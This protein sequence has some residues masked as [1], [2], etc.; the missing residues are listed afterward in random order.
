MPSTRQLEEFFAYLRFPS[1]S[2]DPTQAH[3]CAAC[4]GWLQE[5]FQKMGF[6]ATLHRNLAGP[7]VVLARSPQIPG[8]K[9]LLIYGHYDVQPVDPVDQWSH[10]PFDPIVKNGLVFARGAT[11]NKGQTF[12]H[13]LGAESI[14]QEHGQLP[15]NLIFL[16]D[17]EEEIGSYHLGA[18]LE[19]HQAELACDAIIVSDTSMAGPGIPALTC[20]L[21]GIATLEV[22][23][24]GPATDLH[25]GIFGG[26]VINPATV[27]ARLLGQLHHPDGSVAIPGFY[28]GIKPL[29]E[30]ERTGWN[31]LGFL[32]VDLA[33][34]AGLPRLVGEAGRTALESI[35]A[36][37]T[38]EINGLTA[39]YQGNGSKTIIPQQA[40]AK[41]S[42][43]LV[44]GQRPDA[45][46][47]L[48]QKHLESFST[49]YAQV[50]VCYDHGGEP[51]HTD[52]ESPEAQAILQALQEVFGRAPVLTR[53]G[54]SIPI[55]SLF[56][57]TLVRDTLLVGLGMAD[58]NAH[59]PN[60]SFPLAQL[61]AG[62]AVHR[63]IL[64]RL[65][66]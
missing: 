26:A 58:C 32:E 40:T 14:L 1:I 21:R 5:K 2:A 62:I 56:R 28:D 13:I 15:I 51:Y 34:A 36:R 53:E 25:S 44:P 38:A 18:F 8:R 9:T 19:T 35:W 66:S 16:I 31:E 37:P 22:K 55:V 4:A 63:A 17:G 65:S 6:T 33:R 39:G 57:Q 7:P 27:L 54:L 59:A 3:N 12:S 60:E 50:E 49:E 61:D 64:E 11:D 24:S 29:S 43:R 45:I 20:G 52:T 41:L 10:A 23:V 42:F 30:K 47:A 48:V 46:A